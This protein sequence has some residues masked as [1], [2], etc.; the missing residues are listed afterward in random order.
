[1]TDVFRANGKTGAAL[2]LLY[3]DLNFSRTAHY[4]Q[5]L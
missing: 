2:L 3:R 5:M 1:V 4:V